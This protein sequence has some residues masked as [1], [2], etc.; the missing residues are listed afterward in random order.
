MKYALPICLT[1]GLLQACSL[2]PQNVE[3]KV[4]SNEKSNHRTYSWLPDKSKRLFPTIALE[5]VKKTDE[6]LVEKGYTRLDSDKVDFYLS[7]QLAPKNSSTEFRDNTSYGEQGPGMKCQAGDCES[8]KSVESIVNYRA[9][10][11]LQV[12]AEDAK[13]NEA[14]WDTQSET[15]VDIEY[16]PL[17]N[18]NSFNVSQS[19]RIVGRMI[20][21]ML[22]DVP[23]RK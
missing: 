13:N 11:L 10:I 5:V 17:T 7:F 1:L 20:K 22:E 15:S 21:Q 14:M 9:E 3:T 6:L 19:K 16:N 2:S 4:F 8:T 12:K 18:S 23:A